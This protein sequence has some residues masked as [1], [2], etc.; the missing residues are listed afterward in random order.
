MANKNNEEEL[1]FIDTLAQ[2]M[3]EKG[4]TELEYVKETPDQGSLRIRINCTNSFQKNGNA[5][6]NMPENY[7]KTVISEDKSVETA[8]PQKENSQG[9]VK[10]P[11]VGTVYLSPEPDKPAFITKGDN[12]DK[13]DTLLII[14]AMKTMNQIPAPK[15]GRIMKILVENGNPVEFDSPLVVIE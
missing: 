10:S 4:L 1:T 6:P 12:V 2:L 9:I 11:M 14:E 8:Q 15:A 5:V 3:S 13:G 7:N